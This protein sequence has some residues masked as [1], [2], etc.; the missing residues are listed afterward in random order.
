M[1]FKLGDYIETSY[2]KFVFRG[3][4]TKVDTRPNGEPRYIM[5][6]DEGITLSHGRFKEFGDHI[7]DN[8]KMRLIKTDHFNEDLFTL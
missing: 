8:I 6:P 2:Q 7:C 5:T 3:H 4:I 1:K